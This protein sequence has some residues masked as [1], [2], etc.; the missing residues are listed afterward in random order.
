MA[1]P[2]NT[3]SRR[4]AVMFK[5]TEFANLEKLADM[6]GEYL[7]ETIRWLLNREVARLKRND[8]WETDTY[9]DEG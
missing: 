3:H 1:R 7:A 2:K 8:K 4:L 6:R 5:E 9:Q